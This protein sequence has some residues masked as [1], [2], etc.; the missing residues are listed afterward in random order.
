MELLAVSTRSNKNRRK[1]ITLEPNGGRLVWIQ[2][3]V[4]AALVVLVFGRV[5][6]HDFIVLD[7]SCNIYSNPYLLEPLRFWKE[8]YSHL[9]IPITYMVWTAIYAVVGMKPGVFHGVDLLF[10]LFNSLLVFSIL[11]RVVSPKASRWIAPLGAAIFALHPIQTEAASWAS[12]LKDTLSTFFAFWIIRLDLSDVQ[13]TKR[14]WCISTLLYIATL[15]S[16]PSMVVLPV[17]LALI[18]WGWKGQSLQKAARGL[19]PWLFFRSR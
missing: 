17:I 2:A 9:Y 15:L 6:G 1:A 3:A 12:G 8:S 11:R 16:K 18:R 10:H 7:D 14:G 4:L 19:W 5:V 13:E